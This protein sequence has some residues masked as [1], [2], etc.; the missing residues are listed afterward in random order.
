MGLLNKKIVSQDL[1]VGK[2][3][4][5][6]T[7]VD[8]KIDKNGKEYLA[9]SY[10]ADDSNDVRTKLVYETEITI[11]AQGLSTQFNVEFEETAEMFEFLR[12]NPFRIEVTEVYIPEKDRAYINWVYR[13]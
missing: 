7:S 8:E 3:L 11:M 1:P 6:L 12:N 13:I 10:K 4:I 9:V 5:Q 2:H